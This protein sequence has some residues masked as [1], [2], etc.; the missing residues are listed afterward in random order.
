MN[1]I[2]LILEALSI[3]NI[4]MSPSLHVFGNNNAIVATEER[5]Y[6]PMLITV[7]RHS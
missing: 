5:K 1:K 3:D 7:K 6:L 2:I 4:K